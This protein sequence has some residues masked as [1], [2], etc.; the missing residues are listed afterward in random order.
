[1][2]IAVNL[3]FGYP[4]F[5]RYENSFGG[6]HFKRVFLVSSLPKTSQPFLALELARQEAPHSKEKGT[7]WRALLCRPANRAEIFGSCAYG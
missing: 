6:F 7:P 3:R 4:Q 5:C 2:R 1:M